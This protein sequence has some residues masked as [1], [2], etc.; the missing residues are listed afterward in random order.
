MQYGQWNEYTVTRRDRSAC[1][2]EEK[3]LNMNINITS[4]ALSP[5]TGAQQI[6][7]KSIPIIFVYIWFH[8]WSTK[9]PISLLLST[10]L[11]LIPFRHPL[12][13]LSSLYTSTYYYTNILH[14]LNLFPSSEMSTYFSILPSSL[15]SQGSWSLCCALHFAHKMQASW[16]YRHPLIPISSHAIPIQST[17]PYATRAGN[18]ACP[19]SS[20]RDPLLQH[21]LPH[22]TSVWL[23]VEEPCGQRILR[24]S[25]QISTPSPSGFREEEVLKRCNRKRA[26]PH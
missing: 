17:E 15:L 22:R 20:S 23:A 21:P 24:S 3:Y 1:E 2:G 7:L 6:G 18:A 12:P 13:L 19:V 16:S 8:M 25:Q 9:C 4:V 14:S 26:L 10:T 11:P 5:D